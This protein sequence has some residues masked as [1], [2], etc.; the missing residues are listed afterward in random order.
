MHSNSRLE[1]P[2]VQEWLASLG[3]EEYLENFLDNGFD[4]LEYMILQ[5]YFKEVVLDEFMM[6]DE[7][8]IKNKQIRDDILKRLR[9]GK[10]T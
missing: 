8:G 9:H 4:D 3:Y 6:R 5:T 1:F 10:N 2:K 7:I